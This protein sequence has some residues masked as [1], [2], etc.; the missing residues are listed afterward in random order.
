MNR[1]NKSLYIWLTLTAL[2]L[3]LYF[4]RDLPAY[5]S[6]ALPI[7][8]AFF[9]WNFW[10]YGI[11]K[12]MWPRNFVELDGQG[13]GNRLAREVMLWLTAAIYLSLLGVLFFSKK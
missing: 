8:W 5:P 10:A 2:T 1:K 12:G 13:K 3:L 11:D 4:V 6:R 7:I 9:S